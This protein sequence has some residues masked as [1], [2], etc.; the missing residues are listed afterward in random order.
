MHG[1]NI[2][3]V[4][5]TVHVVFKYLSRSLLEK[6]VASGR[7][8]VTKPPPPH[9]HPI[10]QRIRGVFIQKQRNHYFPPRRFLHANPQ[11]EY[12]RGGARVFAVVLFGPFSSFPSAEIAIMAASLPPLSFFL[13]PL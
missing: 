3:G 6:G 11:R 7:F 13:L 10:S 9:H 5:K 2:R 8:G 4:R 12:L 1:V